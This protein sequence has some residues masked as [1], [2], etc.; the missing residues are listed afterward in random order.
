M[1]LIASHGAGVLKTYHNLTHHIQNT[2]I[3]S[4]QG[5]QTTESQTPNTPTKQTD[6]KD[7]VLCLTLHTITP[8]LSEPTPLP[9]LQPAAPLQSVRDTHHAP[10]L[11]Y[12]TDLAAR[13][14]PV[15]S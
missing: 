14:P 6:D 1:M 13:A 9:S 10:N 4:C 12:L 7:C 11:L 8:T 5:D 2:H 3:D 15:L